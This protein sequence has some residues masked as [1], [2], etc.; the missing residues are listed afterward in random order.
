MLILIIIMF[1]GFKFIGTNYS[2][3]IAALTGILDVPVFELGLHFGLG[4]W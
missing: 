4:H 2:F 1:I 3:L